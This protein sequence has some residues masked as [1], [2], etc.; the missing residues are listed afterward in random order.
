MICWKCGKE[1]DVS[2][3]Y[4]NTE[5]SA[6]HVDLHVCKGCDFYAPGNHFDCRETVDQ[7]IS[8]K[9]K[10]NFCDYFRIKKCNSEIN[11]QVSNTLFGTSAA[12]EED[13]R[14]AAAKLFGDD[15]IKNDSANKSDKDA[16]K[17][18]FNSLFG[19]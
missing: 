10:S 18:A 13:A 5:C 4:R 12:P 15:S 8:D 3:V 6:C 14:S 16:A 17:N 7:L 1:I 11:S 2:Q 9:E 19:D